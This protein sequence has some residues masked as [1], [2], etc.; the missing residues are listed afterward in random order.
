[1]PLV[2]VFWTI[3]SE[4]LV[5]RITYLLIPPNTVVP[6]NSC[7][8]NVSIE[9]VFKI[10]PKLQYHDIIQF[11]YVRLY[12][13]F[14]LPVCNCFMCGMFYCVSIPDNMN[15]DFFLW[16]PFF[17]GSKVYP[18]SN[19]HYDETGKGILQTALQFK[20]T[21]FLASMYSSNLYIYI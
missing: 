15:S 3:L 14:F 7:R 16:Q 19:D 18:V 1:M 4:S 13:G 8:L 5:I 2:P 9:I 6:N 10:H 11:S 20:S 17:S 12:S 21:Y